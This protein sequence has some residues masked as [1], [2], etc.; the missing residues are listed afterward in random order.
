MR[1]VTE[2]VL[3]PSYLLSSASEVSA[4]KGC[5][6]EIDKA[7]SLLK[8]IANPRGPTEHSPTE[9]WKRRCPKPD[10]TAIPVTSAWGTFRIWGLN[11]WKAMSIA[12]P[13]L[14]L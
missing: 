1:K 7:E 12:R 2:L 14:G 13:V 9:F 5:W 3:I 10:R 11:S 4:A 8:Q 6:L